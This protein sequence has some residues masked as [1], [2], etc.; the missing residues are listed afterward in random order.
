MDMLNALDGLG[1]DNDVVFVLKTNRVETLERALVDRPGRVDLAV[2]IPLP[3]DRGL[4]HP[5][6]RPTSANPAEPGRLASP[7]DGPGAIAWAACPA[8]TTPCSP[9]STAV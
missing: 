6:I 5:D 2:E 9:R 7:H 4:E 8:T 3:D 1:E